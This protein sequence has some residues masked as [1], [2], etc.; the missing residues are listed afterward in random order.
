MDKPSTF[1]GPYNNIRKKEGRILSTDEIRQL[2]YTSKDNPHHKEW[3]KRVKSTER[4]LRYLKQKPIDS[5]LDVGSGNG[6]LIH[7]ITAIVPQLTGLDIN[8]LELEQAASILSDY[9]NVKLQYGDIFKL[10]ANPVHDL[11]LFNASIQYFSDLPLLINRARQFLTTNGE[12]HILDSP[13]YA[14]ER[15]AMYAKERT[16]EYYKKNEASDMAQFYHHHIFQSLEQFDYK[17]LYNPKNPIQ[18][19]KRRFIPDMPLYWIRI[20][21]K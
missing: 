3:N 15:E 11:I 16:L 21:F 2:P 13:M 7:N 18:R 10:K 17:I 6:W 20:H 9:D 8:K 4:F 5:L 1:E 12:I 19:F 14:N